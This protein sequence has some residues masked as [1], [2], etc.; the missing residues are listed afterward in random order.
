MLGS[1]ADCDPIF[2][3]S[4]KFNFYFKKL[5]YRIKQQ[6]PLFKKNKMIHLLE[7]TEPLREMINILKTQKFYE[8]KI[9]EGLKRELKISFI[10]VD[11]LQAVNSQQLI[12]NSSL[13][14]FNVRKFII[15]LWKRNLNLRIKTKF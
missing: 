6:T 2:F 10:I 12:K 13:D 14:V 4:I 7:H 8:S 3:F 15:S 11:E 5:V 9:V 1:K